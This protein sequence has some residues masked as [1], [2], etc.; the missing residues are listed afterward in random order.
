[1]R[2]RF[3]FI[4]AALIVIFSNSLLS[5][6]KIIKLA[7][8]V[9][10]QGG[11]LVEIT[12]A[13]FKEAGYEVEIEYL[14]WARAYN[15]GMKGE[16][17]GILGIYYNDKRAQKM[18]YSDVIAKSE[19]VFFK[20]KSSMITYNELEDLRGYRIG[21]IYKSTYPSEFEDADYFEK[22]PAFT[23]V[24]NVKKLINGRI[25][26]FVEKKQVVLMELRN[27]FPEESDKIEC[28]PKALKEIE[29][30]NS[31]SKMYRDSK[32]KAEDFNRGLKLIKEKGIYDEIMA[33][34]LH[35]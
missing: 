12:K 16:V 26:L 9:E 32:K 13:A 11:Y 18:V 28:L 27:S 15:K 25:D 20:R 23:F 2:E 30:Y 35:E 24:I 22:D 4:I 6:D 7:T 14:P 8:D 3:I 31:F 5:A 17:E 19:M 34:K 1:M 29:F 33:R 10:K 21:T